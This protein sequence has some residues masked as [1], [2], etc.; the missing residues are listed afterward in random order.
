MMLSVVVKAT[1]IM[2]LALAGVA[3]ARRSRASVRHLILAVLI[4]GT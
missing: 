3:A 1:I 2:M 4:A